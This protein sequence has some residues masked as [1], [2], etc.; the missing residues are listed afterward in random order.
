[1][2]VTTSDVIVI[3]GRCHC[4]H[5]SVR[6]D[7]Y[8]CVLLECQPCF[9]PE[10]VKC[11]ELFGFNIALFGATFGAIILKNA[12]WSYALQH[13]LQQILQTHYPNMGERA[14][15]RE[16]GTMSRGLCL[17]SASQRQNQLRMEHELWGG[18]HVWHNMTLERYYWF[19]RMC[20][21]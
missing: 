12:H 11:F 3:T 18:F 6:M 13:I 9:A 21:Q 2:S 19:V 16:R 10:S 20:N 7:I 15:F 5:T 17:L 4:H 1:M 14:A 8:Q